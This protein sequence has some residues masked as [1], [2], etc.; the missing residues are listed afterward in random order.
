MSI[1]DSCGEEI[2]F[3]YIDGT[4]RP[5]HING[6]W[7]S[8]SDRLS[9]IDFKKPFQS[10]EAYTSPNAKCPVCGKHVFFYESPNGGRV[11]FDDL[12]WPWPK[13]PCTDSINSQNS[14]I[15]T[16]HP[17][18]GKPF[19]DRRRNVLIIN[20]IIRISDKEEYISIHLKNIY[21]PFKDEYLR[22]DKKLLYKS[23]LIISDFSDAPSFILSD[24][25][26][27]WMVEF[28]SARKSKIIRMKLSK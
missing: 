13:H 28:I 22:I 12:G 19:F 18:R 20:E 7:C 3:R 23:D 1:C 15:S 9:K 26:E 16:F 27:S 21:H 2:E 8:A 10:R 24:Y 11:F 25:G 5:I 14:Q 4:L 6:P 17:S